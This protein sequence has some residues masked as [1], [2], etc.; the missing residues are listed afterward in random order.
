MILTPPSRSILTPSCLHLHSPPDIYSVPFY[1]DNI[2]V[3]VAKKAVHVHQWISRI[4]QLHRHCLHK[5]LVGLDT[6][7]L[8]NFGPDDNHP[9]AIL[10]LCINKQ[11][12][13][14]F[15]FF[16]NGAKPRE[17]DTFLSPR[18]FGRSSPH[19]LRR[20]HPRRRQETLRSP[21]LAV[22]SVADLNKLARLASGDHHSEYRYMGLKKMAVALL[23]KE[24]LKQLQV[25]LSTWDAV[26]LDIEQ[27]EYA[28]ID[29]F[30]SFKL[31]FTLFSRVFH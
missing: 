8:P 27:I 1:A 25:T 11:L 30:V 3:T 15:L 21:R 23:G 12:Y 17:I 14:F 19:L 28:A 24:M 9:I 2:Q 6:E 4:H 31:G 5:L 20:W 29:A 13:I 10:Q 7:W 22:G 16:L 18:L 26:N